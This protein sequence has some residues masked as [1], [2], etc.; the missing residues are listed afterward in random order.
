MAKWLTIHLTSSHSELGVQRSRRYNVVSTGLSWPLLCR[1]LTNLAFKFISG[2][3]N[4]GLSVVDTLY[5]LKGDAATEEELH[6]ARILG[7]LVEFV[8]ESHAP[9]CASLVDV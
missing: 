7:W 4:R 9:V 5:I 2:K 3:L 1:P 8:S 6:K